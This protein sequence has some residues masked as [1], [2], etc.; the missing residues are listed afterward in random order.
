MKDYCIHTSDIARRQHL[1]PAGRRQL[2]KAKF[3]YV[4]W[5]Q[6]GQKLVAD[7]QRAGIWPII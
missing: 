4:I 3:Y 5:S 6:T 1:R 2:F 7:M